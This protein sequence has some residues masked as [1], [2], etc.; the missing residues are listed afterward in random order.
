M[1]STVVSWEK[2]R[3]TLPPAP[4]T[5]SLPLPGSGEPLDPLE[6]ESTPAGRARLLTR[7]RGAFD[8]AVLGKLVAATFVST[9]GRGVF[10]T[11][12]VLY[13]SLI[14]G[15]TPGEVALLLTISG[16]IGV[17][18][19]YLGGHIA[20]LVSAKRLVTVLVVLEAVALMCYP[21]A[22]SFTSA[23]LVACVVTATERAANSARGAIIA[24]AFT[25]SRRVA[26]RAVLRTVTNVGIALGSAAG[27]VALLV[28]TPAAYRWIMVAAGILTLAS[29]SLLARLPRSVDA[30]PREPLA[31]GATRIRGGKP[32]FRN[33]RYLALTAL[34]GIFGMQFGLAEVGVPLWIVHATDAPT[35]LYSM[36]LILNTVLVIAFQ[37]PLSRG[38]H[39]VGY[40]GKLSLVA[41]ALMVV[42]CLFYAGSAGLAVAAAVAFLVAGTIVHSFGEVLSSASNWGLSFELADPLRAGAYQG[43][44]AMGFS[45]GAMAAPLVVTST[46]LSLGTLGWLMLGAIF[47][48]SAAGIWL[49]TVRHSAEITVPVP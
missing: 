33:P 36:L 16:A 31:T 39:D 19:S 12:T 49:I 4:S 42:A 46:T 30:P 20:D 1:P 32:P 11:L 8:D 13:F 18:T 28:G 38:T 24:R 3:V 35:A 29:A 40:A 43:V 22:N 6:V 17:A 14:V 34:S 47:L 2:G 15:L 26:A 7:I 27:G 21:L 41:G 25:G 10:I 9:L 5:G 45:L 44:F 37:V 23:L 48:A